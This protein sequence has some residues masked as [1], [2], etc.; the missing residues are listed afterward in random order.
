MATKDS[1][2][3]F[4]GFS[5]EEIYVFTMQKTNS[6]PIL[7]ATSLEGLANNHHYLLWVDQNF[8]FTFHPRI[9]LTSC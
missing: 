3:T 2:S 6:V 1:E 7:N 9:G 8:L 5:Q 4:N